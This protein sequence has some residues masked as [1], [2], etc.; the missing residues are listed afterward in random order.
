LIN[1]EVNVYNQSNPTLSVRI[2]KG[3]PFLFMELITIQT[4]EVKQE[5]VDITGHL[6][7]EP[8]VRQA[9]RGKLSATIRD[10]DKKVKQGKNPFAF[11]TV[12]LAKK[13]VTLSPSAEQM[14]VNPLYNQVGRLLGIDT[15]REWSMYYDKIFHLAQWAQ[16]KAGQD[17]EQ[18]IKFLMEQSNHAPAMGAK[19]IDDL[20]IY[21]KL[22]T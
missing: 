11:N 14:I 15:K 20:Y 4:P 17:V 19:R 6:A 16:S 18:V 22:K 7:K 2:L 5:A 10:F 3:I 13:P 12:V 9:P 21:S 1:Q 8:A